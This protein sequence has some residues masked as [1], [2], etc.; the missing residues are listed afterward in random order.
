MRPS[1]P[2]IRSGRSGSALVAVMG[3]ALLIA[4]TIV[5]V[6]GL[7]RQQVYTA[8]RMRDLIKAQMIAEAGA[9]Q[10]YHFLKTNF[11]A[12]SNPSN[13]PLTDFDGGT[14]DAAVTLAGTS[15]ASI[16]ATGVY[17]SATAVAML[18]IENYPRVVTNATP[19]VGQSPYG[20]TVAA[21]G[22]LQWVGNQ[23]LETSNSWMYCN[24]IF[25]ANGANYLYANIA[26]HVAINMVGGAHIMGIAQA[27]S[28]TGGTAGS[29]VVASVP[30]MTIPD[31]DLT[32]YY[33][34]ALA[35]SQVYNGDRSIS[36]TVT[37]PGGI[38]WVNGKLYMGNGTYTGCFIATG[39]I[40]IQTT[41][42]GVVTIEKVNS[43]PILVSRDGDIVVKQAKELNFHGLIYCKTGNFDKQGNGDV[44]GVGTIIAAGNVTKNGGWAGM[45]YEDST[46]IPPG[47][48]TVGTSDRVIVTAWQE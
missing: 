28:I 33:N 39:G 3:V 31:I 47:G 10:T 22:Y 36:G 16:I 41:G 46:P 13:F 7:G 38:M 18:D 45:L 35:Q 43:Y 17:R 11:A 42:N 1:T 4:M 25:T 14:Y 15:R 37:P 34:A 40:E 26:S 9:N 30:L 23:N 24:N 27:P 6:V 48:S 29:N 20:C 2:C 5:G 44:Y 19:T 21:G 8:Q 32:P 12:A